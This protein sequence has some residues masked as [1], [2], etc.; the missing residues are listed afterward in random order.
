M[1]HVQPSETSIRLLAG[2]YRLHEQVGSGGMGV[3]HRAT[4]TRLRRPVAVKRV[5]FTE[6]D[7]ADAA[8]ARR[9]PMREAMIA[10][11]VHHPRIVSIFD[12]F[13]DGD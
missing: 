6:L 12:V 5:R 10:A 8:A 13:D 3:V 2:R 11:Q 9:R 1:D 7:G 4:D